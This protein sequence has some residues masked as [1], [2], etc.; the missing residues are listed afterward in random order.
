L[1]KNL[2]IVEQRLHQIDIAATAEHVPFRVE[3]LSLLLSGLRSS[4]R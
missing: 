2:S 3:E 4:M 1:A